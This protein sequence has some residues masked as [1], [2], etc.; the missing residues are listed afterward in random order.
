MSMQLICFGDI[1]IARDLFPGVTF[2][3][4]I[5]DTY[6]TMAGVAAG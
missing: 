3:R 4:R 5:F 1:G 2:S 6:F